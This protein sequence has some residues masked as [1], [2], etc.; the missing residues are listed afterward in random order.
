MNKTFPKQLYVYAKKSANITFLDY[1]E[2]WKS[3]PDGEL[4]AVYELKSFQRL[5]KETTYTLL[6]VEEEDEE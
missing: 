2:N 4:V 3:I 6:P 5:E 1:T